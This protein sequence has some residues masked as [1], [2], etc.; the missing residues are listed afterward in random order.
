MLRLM[1]KLS[2]RVRRLQ[3]GATLKRRCTV[4][5][6]L[7]PP[8]PLSLYMSPLCTSTLNFFSLHIAPGSPS[9]A[10]R[11]PLQCRLSHTYPDMTCIDTPCA[12][13]MLQTWR[14]TRMWIL[15]RSTTTSLLRLPPTPVVR[16]QVAPPS[17]SQTSTRSIEGRQN[18]RLGLCC[19]LAFAGSIDALTSSSDDPFRCSLDACAC[20]CALQAHTC[21]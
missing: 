21:L 17:S 18:C 10:D 13:A 20:A 15:Q 6:R 16:R 7:P 3:S 12:L 8:P 9:W 19:A 1:A 11:P 2:T 4:R 14:R 5:R